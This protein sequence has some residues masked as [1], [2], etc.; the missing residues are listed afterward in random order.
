MPPKQGALQINSLLQ[1][2]VG[3]IGSRGSLTLM[4]LMEQ[5]DVR[6]SQLSGK[7]LLCE[8]PFVQGDIEQL[9]EVLLLKGIQAWNYPTL[10]AMMTVGIGIYYYNR[11]DFWSEFPGLDSPVDRSKWGQKFEDFLK[12]RN[13]LET[14]RSVKDE[15]SHRYVGPILAHGGIPQ[16][17]LPDFFSLI[18]RYGDR[19]QSGQD[20]I[21]II[22]DK[23]VYVDKPVQRFM[24]Y[25]G[26]VAEDFVSRFLA[27]W[28]H[29]ERGDMNAKCKLPDR[30]VDAFSAWWPDHKPKKRSSSKRMPKPELRLEPSGQG[31]FLYLPRCDSHPDVGANAQWHVLGKEWAVTRAHEIPITE[32]AYKW[33]IS[34]VGRRYTLDGPTDELPFLFF[35][36]STGKVIPEPHLRRLPQKVWALFRG[37]QQ[38]EPTP[39]FEEEFS[40]WPGYFLAVFDLINKYQLHIG[41]NI[42]DVRKPFFHCGADPVVQGVFFKDGV[43]VFYDLPEIKWNGEANL[44]LTV[45]GKP[46]GNIDIDSDELAV[47]LDKP[48]EYFIE[49]RGPLGESPYK[50]FVLV[51]GL[52]VQ[53]DPPIVWQNKNPVKWRL[54]ASAGNIQS[55]DGLP[56]FIRCG[57]KFEFKVVYGDSEIDLH[58]DAPQ[59]SLR[60]LPQQEGHD[61]TRE[62][63]ALWLDELCQSNYPLLECAF[64]K[65]TLDVEVVL[66]ARHSANQLKA[67]RQESGE[68]TSW[69]FDL[70]VVR[71]V[72][73]QSGKSE[74]FDLLIRERNGSEFFRGKVMSARPRWDLR[75]FSAKWKKIEGRHVIDVSWQENGKSITGRWLAVIPLWEPGKGAILR[76]EIGNDRYDHKWELPLPY[77]MPGR[78]MVKA[79]HAPWGCDDWIDAQAAIEQVVDVYPESW[80]ET[81]GKQPDAITVGFYLQALLAHWY[82]PQLVRSPPAAPTGLTANEIIRFLDGLRL[83][84][85][86]EQVKI[87]E[88]GSGSLNIFCANAKATTE[89]YLA[90]CDQK[91]ADIW[92]SVLPG[93]EIIRVELNGKDKE[94]VH[95]VAFQ[96]SILGSGIVPNLKKYKREDLS[97]ILAVWRKNISKKRPPVDEV[98]FLCEKFRLFENEP[99]PARKREYE[100]LKFEYQSR[101]AI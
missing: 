53:T 78:Y 27:L 99:S 31:V 5:E 81:F 75:N 93:K 86:L 35:D 90:I 34:G 76:H 98:I 50:H 82:R 11:G 49:L 44:S 29:Y 65:L 92:E 33:E 55:G 46:Q 6:A 67:K 37:K 87:P 41:N 28:Q 18:T 30:V 95:E 2:N 43:P 84:D 9:R 17:C 58:A 10:A 52:T 66:V 40:Y 23:P 80:P 39:D 19:E 88:D 47:L 22:K 91:M 57:S 20:L 70:R 60:L 85:K 71:D 48:G 26:E 51:P 83:A 100:K 62:P 25:G 8:I 61:W 79:V 32:P 42:F 69:Y 45:N 12:G 68:Q 97:D 59:L 21:E 74:E 38:T 7:R 96:Y 77:L 14:F 54:S 13:S 1:Q 101:E 36:P 72:L 16:T 64:G 4:D 73:E 63:M 3:D 56:P 94:F 15:G 24:K 89:A